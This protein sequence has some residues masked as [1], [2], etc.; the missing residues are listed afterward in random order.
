M[1]N[2]NYNP[3]VYE[4]SDNEHVYYN[5]SI[6]NA[7]NG[8]D[9]A[10]TSDCVYDKQSP[11][12]ILKQSDYELAVDSWQVRAQLPIMITTI[13]EGILATDINLTPYSVTYEFTTGGITTNFKT[14]LIYLPDPKFLDPS[15]G[16]LP[17]S[18][19]QNNGLQDLLTNPGY[20]WATKYNTMVKMMNTALTTSY[21]AFNA[22]H[23]GIHSAPC[24][25]QYNPQTGLFAMVAESSYALAANPAKIFVDTQLYKFIDT[26]PAR[27]YGFNRP[28][29]KEYQIDFEVR[30]NNSNA[31]VVG[32]V[33]AGVVPNPQTVVPDFI[34]MQQETDSRGLWNNITQFLVTSNSISVRDEYLPYRSK[35]QQVNNKDF[36]AFNQSKRS[37]ISYID[38]N[39]TSAALAK[40]TSLSRDIIYSPKYRKWIDLVSNDGLNSINIEFF[41]VVGG[42]T[43]LPLNLPINA[44]ADVS[45][46]FKKKRC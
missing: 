17:K 32:N 11:N 15:E 34:I 46:V 3:S 41:Y 6:D 4:S 26:V 29:S 22:A 43:I 36:D 8:V 40:Q 30:T 31:Y 10:T 33:D 37:V 18:P 1:S 9:N 12:I 21:N 38:Y 23:G 39:S 45:L 2:F 20:Y 42:Q 28:F 44:S 27:F 13:K 24:Y 16:P 25:L 35:P 14:E 7:F 5:L 19:S